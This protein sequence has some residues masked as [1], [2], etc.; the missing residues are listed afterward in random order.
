MNYSGVGFGAADLRLS[1]GEVAAVVA[2]DQPDRTIFVGANVDLFGLTP[3]FRVFEAGGMKFGVT[4]VLGDEFRQQVNNNELELKPAAV[5]LKEVV[6]QL[7]DCDHRILLANATSEEC[8]VL[9]KQ[10]PQFDIMVSG[11]GPD[12]PLA[13]VKRK[14]GEALVIEVG[15]KAMYAIVLGFFDDAKQPIRYQRVA[16][17]SRFPDSDAMKD[18]M[19]RYQSQL[20]ALGWEGLGLRATPHPQTRPDNPLSGQFVGGLSCKECHEA[21]W[22]VYAKSPH[23]HATET[24][25]KLTPARHFDPECVS[26]HV[27]GWMPQEFSPFISGFQSM[28]KTPEL[29]GQSCENC[30]GPGAAHIAAERGA[31]KALQEE[32]RKLMHQD[33]ATAADSCIKCHDQDNSPTFN[34]DTYWPEIEH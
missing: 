34:F 5:A 7:K 13:D 32:W 28:E 21:A 18:L 33:K 9:G 3:R 1:A 16:L 30:H 24:L 11:D 14:P 4:A 10:F 12:E 31:D 29:A 8:A 22:D 15:H 26:C 27:T 20:Q 6:D 25:I 19:T 17:D 23:A 2:G